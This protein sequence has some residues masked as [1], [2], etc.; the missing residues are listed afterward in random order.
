MVDQHGINME[1]K[2]ITL[3]IGSWACMGIRHAFAPLVGACKLTA[4][5]KTGKLA[6]LALWLDQRKC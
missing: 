3:P 6:T 4:L 1:K 2:T 5:P